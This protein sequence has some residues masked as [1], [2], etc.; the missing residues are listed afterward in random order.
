MAKCYF[1]SIG[2]NKGLPLLTEL[3][4]LF[5]NIRKKETLQISRLPPWIKKGPVYAG[6]D[7]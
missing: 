7:S 5:S 6:K 4:N 2:E 1:K 3:C